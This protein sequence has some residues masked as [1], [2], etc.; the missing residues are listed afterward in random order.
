MRAFGP[1][2][3]PALLLAACAGGSGFPSLLPRPA[4][5][6]RDTTIAAT[7]V[8]GLSAEESATLGA[9]MDR[10]E[11]ALAAAEAAISEAAAR[12]SAAMAAARGAP[13][14]SDRWVEAQIALSRYDQA[15][16]GLGLVIG[17]LAGLA[18]LLDPLATNQ[19]ER[20]RFEA[21]SRRA[22]LLA[23]ESDAVAQEA[24]RAL[25]G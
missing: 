8:P 3:L 23:L 7:P 20:V 13:P 25:G 2:L 9:E 18:P 10:E 21:L 22:D 19:P 11:A 1:I 24:G 4:E 15:R 5:T 17:R 14:G 6:P 12:L 16:A